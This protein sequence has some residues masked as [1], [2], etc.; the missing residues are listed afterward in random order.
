MIIRSHYIEQIRP[1]F[2]SDLIKVITGI[3][4]CGKSVILSQIADEYRSAS[5]P[6]LFINFE[7]LEYSSAISDAA[8]LTTYVKERIPAE[9]KLYVFLDEVQLV[10]DWNIACRSLRLEIISLF[11]TGSNSK[12]LSKE[13]TK[14]LSGR[15]V[16]FCVRPFV[17]KEIIDYANQLGKEYSIADYL[18]YGGFPKVIELPDK[19]SIAQYLNDLNQTI[20][21]NDIMTRYKI[22]KTELFKRLVNYVLISNARIFSANS[23]QHYLASEKLNCSIN[24][25]MK[26]LSYL[27]EAYVIRKIPQYSTR[28]K[29]ELSFYAKIYDEDVSF[30]TIRQHK[31]RFDLTHNLENIVFN[32]LIFMGY[33]LTVFTKGNQEIDFMANKS[34]KEYLIQVAYSVAEESTYNREFALFNTLDQ[35]KK[36]ILITNDAVDYSTSTVEHISLSRFLGMKNLEQL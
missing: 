5:K 13:F 17:Y 33:E 3:R 18:V 8:A 25:V 20:I 12:L 19:D 1:F 10:K 16:S 29:R 27:E 7:N 32:E 26:Y 36:K 31:G 14:E 15:Y 4:R 24:T 9:E 28:A 30:N 2:E 6:V 23:I 21:I 35:S 22:R 34:G 11:I